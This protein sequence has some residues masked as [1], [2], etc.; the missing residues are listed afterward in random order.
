MIKI[1]FILEMII[2]LQASDNAT[3]VIPWMTDAR[4]GA[5]NVYTKPL[6]YF[7]GYYINQ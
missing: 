6:T 2:S 5:P 1:Q 7:L 3:A 4:R